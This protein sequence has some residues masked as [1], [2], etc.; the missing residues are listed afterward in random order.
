MLL[1][2]RFWG[3]VLLATLQIPTSPCCF[4]FV[5]KG[6]YSSFEC[7]AF[8]LIDVRKEKIRSSKNAPHANEGKED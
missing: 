3:R 7:A 6:T 2:A 4:C 5:V 1:T 8:S